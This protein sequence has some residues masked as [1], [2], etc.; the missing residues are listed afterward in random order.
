MVLTYI[1]SC[2]SNRF[3]CRARRVVR[4]RQRHIVLNE[5]PNGTKIMKPM[6]VE[7]SFYQLKRTKNIALRLIMKCNFSK[8]STSLRAPTKF[9]GVCL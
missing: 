4:C 7:E 3:F 1:A 9:E 2:T 8:Y 5:I 6:E